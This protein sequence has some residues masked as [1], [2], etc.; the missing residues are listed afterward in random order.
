[1]AEIYILNIL[2]NVRKPNNF[3]QK[4]RR[5]KMKVE[6]I[7]LRGYVDHNRIPGKRHLGFIFQLDKFTNKRPR[8]YKLLD[9]F[10]TSFV[11]KLSN[12]LIMKRKRLP[13]AFVPQC[14]LRY[15]SIAVLKFSVMIAKSCFFTFSL[16]SPMARNMFP[17][18]D[19]CRRQKSRN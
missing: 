3:L 7:S 13:R 4:N 1:M 8:F 19:N 9:N 10:Q 11:W 15:S 6:L 2:R 5:K 16:I 18:N 14:S 12:Y 17:F